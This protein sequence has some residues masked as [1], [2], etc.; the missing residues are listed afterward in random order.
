MFNIT[1][2][3]I[4]IFQLFMVMPGTK[5][6]EYRV[7]KDEY[8]L[9]CV[10]PQPTASKFRKVFLYNF[11]LVDTSFEM[12]MGPYFPPCLSIKLFSTNSQN[13]V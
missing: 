8:T 4:F 5:G 2:E 6:L 3:M 13:R 9:D 10:K 11:C 7:L 1:P 12:F